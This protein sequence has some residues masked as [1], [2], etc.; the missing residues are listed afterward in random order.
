MLWTAE[1]EV[2]LRRHAR[3]MRAAGAGPVATRHTVTAAEHGAAP[4]PHPDDDASLLATHGRTFHFATRFMPASLRGQVVTLYAFFRTLDD[5]VDVPELSH[6]E[7]AVRAE[8]EA[9]RVWF[10]LGHHQCAPREPLGMRLAAILDEHQLPNDIF[11]DFLRGLFMDLDRHEIERFA[12]LREYC[13]CVAGTVGLAMAHLLGA[14]SPQALQAAEALGIAMQLTNILRDVGGDLRLGRVYLPAD[15]L[16]SAGLS[17]AHLGRLVEA[18]DGPD[19]AVREL[20]RA[21]VTRA[22]AYYQRGMAGIWLLPAEARL[23]ILIAA[24]L[25][26]AILLAIH[27]NG[28]DVLRY[29]AATGLSEKLSEAA[30]ALALLYLWRGGEDAHG[31]QVEVQYVD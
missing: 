9:W 21:Q 2:V 10:A 18:G 12:D 28:Y 22:H 23:T 1:I 19:E 4:A 25:Y 24:R 13:Y 5:L 30:R 3:K 7:A 15:E 31:G 11:L 17:R 20:L 29:R 14:R 27:R 26:R 16:R 6:G 8:L